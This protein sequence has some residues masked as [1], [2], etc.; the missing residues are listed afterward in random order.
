MKKIELALIMGCVLCLVSCNDLDLYPL[1]KGSSETWFTSQSQFEMAVNDF[2]RIEFWPLAKEAWTDDYTYR[3][4]PGSSIISGTLNSE[5]EIVSDLWTNLY[6]AIARTN[7]VLDNIKVGRANGISEELLLQYEAE[8]KFARAAHYAHLVFTFGDV[9]YIDTPIS[10]EDAYKMSR[11]PKDVV[12][13]NI[14]NDFDFAAANLPEKYSQKNR[15]TR[16]AA[17]AL[18]ARYA[19]YFGDYEVAEK[20]A[21]EC[22]DLQLYELNDDF[23]SLFHT[24]NAK[25]SIFLLPRSLTYE[26]GLVG[27]AR[28]Y[29]SRTAG[30][31]SSKLPSWDLFAIF[32]CT[33]GKTIDDSPLFDSHEPFK[34]RDPRCSATIV[35]F[36]TEHLGIEYTPHPKELKVMNYK[37]GKK[38]TNKDTR[39]KEQFASYNGLIWKKGIDES[40]GPSTKYKPEN[41]YVIIRYA[42]VLLIYA[43]AKI[44]QNKIDKDVLDAINL[45]RARAYGVKLEDRS[46]Y[47]SITTTDQKGLRNIL[48]RERRVEFAFEGLRYYDIIRWKIAKKVFNK[49]NCGLLYPAKNLINK[50]VD[51]GHW[52]WP[53][54]PEIDEDGFV[55]FLKMINSGLVQVLSKG[56]WSD[57]QYLWP[58]PAKERIINPNL[59]QN[60]GY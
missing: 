34:N 5:E 52:F 32:E 44:E 36:G 39:A 42:D 23:A 46:K 53:Y 35:E 40:W 54:A 28:S 30:G 8:A 24:R 20:A 29:L 45:V 38:V 50:V 3:D 60:P 47:P 48:R 21:K 15:A 25:E 2:Y 4:T 41:D 11:S 1:E 6:K 33:D 18:K 17:L 51:K 7:T 16:G 57:R 49:P 58:I 10:I 13:Q 14:Y 55:D 19:L 12:I 37:T 43:E 27:D 59:D 31:F 26:V 56:S 9:V 22:M